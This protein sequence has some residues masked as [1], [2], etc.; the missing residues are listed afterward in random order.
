MFLFSIYRFPPW[1]PRRVSSV[2]RHRE[3]RGAIADYRERKITS[4]DS[5]W[6]PAVVRDLKI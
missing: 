1:T 3:S 5:R 6:I 2:M 4:G